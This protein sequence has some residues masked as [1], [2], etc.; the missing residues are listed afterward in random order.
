MMKTQGRRLLVGGALLWVLAGF[1][2]GALRLAYGQRPAYVHVRWAATVDEDT[3]GQIERAHS[4]TRGALREGRTW[5]YFLTD[6]ST[7]NI[8]DLI[9]NPR[10]EDTHQIH[11]T[12]FRIWR[13]AP[14]GA[15]LSPRPAWIAWMLEWLTPLFGVLGAGAFGAAALQAAGGPAAIFRRRRPSPDSRQP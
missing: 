6:L 5:G 9:G 10:V 1:A 11:R 3:R 14:R 2:Y 12:A 15:Y 13:T 4:L 7:S 8:R